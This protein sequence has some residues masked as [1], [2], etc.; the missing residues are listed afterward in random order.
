MEEEVSGANLL[1]Q[2]LKGIHIYV[3][4]K[5]KKPHGKHEDK[6]HFIWKYFPSSANKIQFFFLKG[7]QN[8]KKQS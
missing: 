7:K 1:G 6:Q 4:G 8:Q 5:F 2:Q 3:F